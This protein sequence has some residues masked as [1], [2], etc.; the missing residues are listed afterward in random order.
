VAEWHLGE[1]VDFVSVYHDGYAPQ[2]HTREVLF[3]KG[4]YALIVDH[5]SNLEVNWVHTYR[6]LLHFDFDVEVSASDDRLVAEAGGEAMTVV[7]FALTDA[8]PPT[9]RMIR[10][11]RDR[12]LDPE[13]QKLGYHACPWVTDMRTDAVGP[14]VLIL[15]LYPHARGGAP[16]LRL[17]RLAVTGEQGDIPASGA[18]ALTIETPKGH[19]IWYRA[20]GTAGPVWF[21]ESTTSERMWLRLNRCGS[22]PTSI[23]FQ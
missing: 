14:V 12:Y 18:L 20:F 17:H 8:S 15:L 2:R 16:S 5:V 19:D 23:S 13:R 22:E 6:Q 10:R 11:W 9:D 21:G 1:K 7:P 4:D 3:V